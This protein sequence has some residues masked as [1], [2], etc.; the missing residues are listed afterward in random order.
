MEEQKS[1]Q[2]ES[3]FR[4]KA[5]SRISSPE[6]LDQYLT[7]TGPGVWLPLLAVIVLLIGGIV[8]MIFGQINITMNVAVEA[9][10]GVVVCY[11]PGEQKKSALSGGSVTIAGEK[12]TLTDVGYASQL[13]TE[14]MNINVRRAGSLE[15]GT[16]VAPLTVDAP[17]LPGV[18]SG[19]ITVETVNP[20]K[21][22]IN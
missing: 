5:L 10:D 7:V 14:E 20:I 13:V 6:Q 19:Q 4:K 2:K 17:L 9:S 3:I 12:Y 21:Y 16:I 1:T 11:V 18:Y 22:I 8:W 15:M